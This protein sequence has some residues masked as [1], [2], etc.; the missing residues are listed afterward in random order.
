MRR[1]LHRALHRVRN[2]DWAVMNALL[3]GMAIAVAVAFF[4]ERQP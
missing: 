4:L 3:L 2:G 1:F